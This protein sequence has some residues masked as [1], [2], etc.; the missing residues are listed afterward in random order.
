MKITAV[1]AHALS[2]PLDQALW[3][4]HEALKDSSLILVEVEAGG[5]TGYGIIH[6]APMKAIAD[7]VVR[8]GEIIDGDDALAHEIIWNKLFML[9]VPRP[10][11][12]FGADGLVP[13]IAR[14]AR[15]QVMAAI[16]GIDIALWDLKG[17]A[18]KMPVYKLLGGQNR[19]VF[20]YSTGGYY[21]RDATV[22]SA[23]E[24]MAAFVAMGYRAVK[25]KTGGFS[26]EEEIERVA[27][28]RAAIPR[29]T[30]LMLDLNAAYGLNDCIR[31]ARGV[32]P[33]DITWLEEPLHWYL[34]PD[35]YVQLA[36]ATRIPLSHGEREIHRFT[37]RDFIECGAIKYLQFDST[38]A[39]GFTESIKVAQLAEQHGVYVVPHHSPE[40]HAHL[41]LALPDVGYCVESHGS[42]VRD[43]LPHHVFRDRVTF[44]DGHIHLAD[45]PGFGLN[46]DWQAV[47][48]YRV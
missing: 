18:A 38:R 40:I 6:G 9:T 48:R 39:A 4:A 8:F 25:L 23:A 27:A 17:K 7:W 22:H 2:Y 34:Q 3:T 24:E 36:A 16:G 15:A 29:D 42:A 12:M 31:F 37:V 20:T 46:I 5:L 26:V 33:Y 30:L 11:A 32:E 21:P 28:V 1:R 45:T 10:R 41:V 13:P 44:R 47:E 14:S 43:P 35:D 19:P